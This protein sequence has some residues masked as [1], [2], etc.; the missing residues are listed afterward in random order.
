MTHALRSAVERIDEGGRDAARVTHSASSD[1]EQSLAT[2]AG[3][4]AEVRQLVG[5][6]HT[7]ESRLAGLDGSLGA[8]RGMSRTIQKIARQTNMLALNATIEAARAGELG[9]GFAV[10]ATEVKTLARQTDD[11]THGIDGTVNTLSGDIDD[12][13]ARS[14]QT[15]GVAE[16]VN[17]GVGVISGAIEGLQGDIGKVEGKVSDIAVAA[18]SCLGDCD[19]V[20]ADIDRFSDGMK[21]TLVSLESAD[22]RVHGCLEYGEELLNLICASG[23]PTADSPFIKALAQANR[24]VT[25][26]FEQAIG[27]GRLTLGELFDETYVPIAG[28]NPPQVTTRYT[29]LTDA[30][31]PPI[32]EPMLAFDPRVVF[33]AAVDRNGY[34]PTHNL[35]FSQPQGNDPV[36][37]NAHCRNR[38]IF[39][40][41]VGLRAGQNQ[42]PFLLQAYRRDMGGGKF[43]L[44]KDLS[45]PITVNGR[46]WGGL[47]LAYT[48]AR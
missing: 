33:C 48:M 11:A 37:N 36:W 28:S 25:E 23:L 46:H 32:Q 13:I 26:A 10:V 15:I 17:Q 30:L 19:K 41:R 44:M 2:V 35:K 24:Q 27:E 34:L 43:V 42:K 39:N 40:D 6:V 3:A 1:S 9:R 8:V 20:I 4:I 47:R 5:A 18:A 21:T 22:S 7:I 12:L 38:R 29:T 45:M 16:S 14:T 31:L